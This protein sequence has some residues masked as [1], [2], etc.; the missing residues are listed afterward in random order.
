MKI[1]KGEYMEKKKKF[2]MLL[3]SSERN[4]SGIFKICV[5]FDTDKIYPYIIRSEY[6]MDKFTWF[7]NKG[8]KRRAFELLEKDETSI[9]K[10]VESFQQIDLTL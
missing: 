1:T 2:Q 6:Y 4:S 9:T 3:I 5:K 7:Y 8:L 10:V